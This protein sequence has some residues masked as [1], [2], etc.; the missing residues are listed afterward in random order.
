LAIIS[1]TSGLAGS[2]LSHRAGV[3][4]AIVTRAMYFAQIIET[5]PYRPGNE[6]CV[7]VGH[8]DTVYSGRS[9]YRSGNLALSV[10]NLRNQA[11]GGISFLH[12]LLFSLHQQLMSAIEG[13]DPA[14]DLLTKLS[15][16]TK[17]PTY[18]AFAELSNIPISTIWVRTQGRQSRREKATTQQ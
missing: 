4:L 15:D 8:D 1:D 11:F 5:A 13:G 2:A 16:P 18:D 14:T 12:S 10:F 17:R 6:Y 3:F 7:G 9:S